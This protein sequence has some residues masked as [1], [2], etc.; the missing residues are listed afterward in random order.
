MPSSLHRVRFSWDTDRHIELEWVKGRGLPTPGL[1]S[2]PFSFVEEEGKPDQ[3]ALNG[4]PAIC[5]RDDV[6]PLFEQ[7]QLREHTE[8]FLDVTLPLG[9]AEAENQAKGNP[10]WP[11]SRRL[12]ST[13]YS[14]PPRRWRETASGAVVI[15]GQL[16]LKNHAGILDLNT[17]FNTPLMAEVVC[18]K[19]DYLTEFKALLDEVSNELAELL[20]Q[21]DSPLSFSFNLSDLGSENDAALLF[22]MRHIMNPQNLPV[23]VDEV[24]A[25][26][27]SRLTEHLVIESI[28]AV[29]EPQVDALVD[30]LDV[31]VLGQG[32]PLARLFRG[33][34]PTEI[35]VVETEDSVDTSENRY[36]KYF[37]EECVLIAERLAVRLAV[38]KKPAAAREAQDWV[39]RLDEMLAHR[40]WL[41]VGTLRQFPSNSQVLHRRRGYREMLK[42]DLA[43]RL[44]LELSWRRGD[45]FADG[46]LGDVRP[47]NEIYEYWCFFVLRRILIGMCEVELPSNGSFIQLAAD[48]LQVRLE[49][50]RRSR[51]SFLYRQTSTR[52]LQVCLFFNRRFKR[53]SRA[54]SSWDGSYTAHFDPDYSI[55]LTVSRGDERDRHWLHFD[56]K[57]RLESNEVEELFAAHDM[58]GSSGSGDDEAT[59]YDR[60][61]A[62]LHKRDDLFK[63]HTYRD[64]IL[65]SRGAYILFPGVGTEIRLSGT[66]Q[67]LFVR[68]PTA[69]AGTPLHKFPGV[70]AFDLCPGHG[71]VQSS[72]IEHFLKEFF[73]AVL[74]GNVYQEETGLF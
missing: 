59:A 57:Y 38:R 43:L 5:W 11:F 1:T 55:L 15:S 24:L 62:R 23:A 28:S 42:F 64:G 39:V 8:Y 65:S 14:D 33:Y 48:G 7:F 4:I 47:V 71:D 36:V 51:I 74:D 69:F 21:Y 12:A 58:P 46:L 54:L 17:D 67:N 34:T 10:A 49:K 20:L 25:R 61:I 70:G 22:Q 60:E 52:S 63:M 2:G 27:H 50:G 3:F 18:R 26:F 68:H 16:R 13:F 41:S 6:A 31:S 53:P 19:I 40:L 32:G 29:Q 9:R 30:E 45:D 72:V 44:S 35:A 56:A 73:E 37:L 66:E